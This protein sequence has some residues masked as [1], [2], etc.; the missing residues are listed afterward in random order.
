MN[1]DKEIDIFKNMTEKDKEEVDLKGII[2][3]LIVNKRYELNMSQ[4]EFADYVGVTQQTIS[5]YENGEYNFSLEFVKP[6]LNKFNIVLPET[7][8]L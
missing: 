6:L 4:K 1:I 7:N 2:A 8:Y 5:Q 3:G